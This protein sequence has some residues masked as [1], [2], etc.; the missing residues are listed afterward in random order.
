MQLL[1]QMAED[2]AHGVLVD[3]IDR[4]TDDEQ[5]DLIAMTW[6]GRGDFTPEAWEG[7]RLAAREISRERTPEYLAGLPLFG[8]YLAEGLARYGYRLRDYVSV[9]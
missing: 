8:D 6:I 5:V 9:H 7:A 3:A 4:L 2:Y 1:E